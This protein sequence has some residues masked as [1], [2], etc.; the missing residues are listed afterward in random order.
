MR[1]ASLALLLL[2]VGCGGPHPPDRWDGYDFN[3]PMPNRVVDGVQIT[4]P[5]DAEAVREITA[6][7][8]AETDEP[9][10]HVTI[11]TEA[12]HAYFGGADLAG[13]VA[14]VKTGEACDGRCGG[15]ETFTLVYESGAWRIEGTGI[16]TG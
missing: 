14:E 6:L 16:W 1:L 8:R 5:F 12:M 7:V 2:L 4:G 11:P 13:D 10:L 9:I 15:G 3:R